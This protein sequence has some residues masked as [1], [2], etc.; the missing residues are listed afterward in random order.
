MKEAIKVFNSW[1]NQNKDE[2]ME[3]NHAFSV[4][5]MLDLIPSKKLLSDFSFIDIGCGNGWVVKKMGAAKNCIKSVGIDGAEKMIQKAMAKDKNSKYFQFN[6]ENMRYK[7]Q[8]DI[9]FSME[10]FYYFK[11]PMNV[12]NYIYK[13]I[14]KPGGSM[15]I[16]ID[17]YLENPSS[18]SWSKDL[19]LDLQTYSINQWRSMFARADFRNIKTYQFGAKENWSGTLVIYAEK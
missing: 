3:K 9:I 17:H 6:I 15:I 13:Y 2:G 14:L 4:N 7:E 8:F 19:N 1:A 16:G 18:L 12:L 11:N 10:V 5:K